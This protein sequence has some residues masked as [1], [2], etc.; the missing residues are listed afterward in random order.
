[1]PVRVIY[2]LGSG[3]SGSTVLD[4]VLGHHADVVGVGELGGLHRAVCVNNEYCA[5]GRRGR[6]CPF[7]VDVLTRWERAVG[8]ARAARYLA[9]QRRFQRLGPASWAR[10]S[11]GRIALTQSLGR[12]L[13]LTHELYRSIAATSG[14]RIVVDSSKNPLRAAALARIPELDLRLIHLVRDG[15]AVAWSV[16]KP[17]PKNEQAGVHAALRPHPAWRTIGYWAVVNLLAEWVQRGRSDRSVRIRYEDFV[18]EPRLALGRIGAC[19]GLEFGPVADDVLAGRPIPVGHTIAGNRLRMAGSVRLRPDW[20]WL[21]KLP[22]AD[23]S[24][25]WRL[26]GP[27][28]KHYGYERD[29]R[30]PAATAPK[31]PSLERKAG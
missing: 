16:K 30:P 26:A 8:P 19:C 4:T 13:Q 31:F 2:I 21:E 28:L 9:L 15:R 29:A 27:L 3:R 11:A 7:W 12:Y 10:L 17:L 6:E 5:C 22:A 23:R 25:C 14:K 24:L 20:E 1:L 18:S